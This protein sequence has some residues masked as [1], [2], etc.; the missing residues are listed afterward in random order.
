MTGSL[1][2]LHWTPRVIC[3][4]AIL[5]IS[6]FA[7]DA[8]NPALP[9]GK[10]IL[11]FLMHMLPSFVLTALL[12]IAWKWELIGGIILGMI[13]IVF[14]PI[15]FMHN[16]N[17]NHSVVMSLTVIAMITFPFILVGVLFVISHFKKKK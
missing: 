6:L 16:Y 13:G 7:L 10:Q 11:D 3:I 17:M 15:I 14:S 5:F 4:L 9:I 12:I 1:K 8:F 2:L